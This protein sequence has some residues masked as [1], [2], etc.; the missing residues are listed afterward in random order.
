MTPMFQPLESRQLLSAVL[1]AGTLTVTGTAKNDRISITLSKDLATVTVKETSG[2]RF[3]KGTTTSTD[4]T[5]ADVTSI[6][7]NAGAGNDS[8]ALRGGKRSTPFAVAATINGDAGNDNL[9]GAAGNDTINGGEGDDN[10][11][12]GKG[13][14]LLNGDAGDDLLV[15]GA[16]ID[17]LNGGAG[18]DLLVSKGDG[19]IDIVDGGTDSAATGEDDQDSA[20]SDSNESPLNA[21]VVTPADLWHGFGHGGGEHGH[22]GHGG[23]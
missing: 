19:V 15:G 22:G 16:D 9:A 8:V 13:T 14:D 2:S 5:A 21:L 4:F 12:G 20:L 1:S 3:R 6:V 7:V 11:Y 10:L 18:D 23:H 17:T